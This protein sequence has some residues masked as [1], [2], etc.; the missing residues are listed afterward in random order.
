MENYKKLLIPVI[1]I[2]VAGIVAVYFINKPSDRTRKRAPE[3]RAPSADLSG[4]LVD[5]DIG[6]KLQNLPEDPAA[7]AKMGDEYFEKNMF[8]PAIEIY[9]KAL[10][11]NPN[12]IDTYN[13]LGLAYHYTGQSATAI[14]R[15][16]KGTEVMPSYQRIWLSLGYILLSSDRKDEARPVLKKAMEL[17]PEST[18]GV[19]AKRMLDSM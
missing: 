7:L 15:L 12:D 3:R 6:K 18:V 14:E 8:G 1:I 13:D 16:R 4:P 5:V 17:A 19:E 9:E 11:L 10:K 2:I